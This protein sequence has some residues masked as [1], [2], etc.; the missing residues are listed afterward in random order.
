M[1]RPTAPSKPDVDDEEIPVAREMP[2]GSSLDLDADPACG[3]ASMQKHAPI[4]RPASTERPTA[5]PSLR[6]GFCS[7]AILCYEILGSMSARSSAPVDR[8]TPQQPPLPKVA[9][10]IFQGDSPFPTV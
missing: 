1:P 3:I 8:S 4:T 9:S 7:F 5:F 10:A 6:S 2:I